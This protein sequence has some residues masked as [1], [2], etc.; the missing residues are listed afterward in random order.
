MNPTEAAMCRV[1]SSDT[2]VLDAGILSLFDEFL[3]RENKF[4]AS[5][6]MLHEYVSVN[7]TANVVLRIFDSAT[8]S[9]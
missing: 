1:G 2:S 3:R 5:Y 7:P 9:G 4:L 6:R 8:R